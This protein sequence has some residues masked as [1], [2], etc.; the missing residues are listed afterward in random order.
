MP[1]TKEV[2][3]KIITDYQTHEGDTGSRKY[4][5]RSFRTVSAS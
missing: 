5:L 3:T 2:K 1:L 4:R